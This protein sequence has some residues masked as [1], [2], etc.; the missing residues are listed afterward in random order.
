MSKERGFAKGLGIQ[1]LAH[2]DSVTQAWPLQG[3]G[4]YI[5]YQQTPQCFQ[6][7]Y[8]CITGVVSDFLKGLG[9]AA[10]HILR[11]VGLGE[12]VL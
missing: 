8:E 6:L 3:L 4:P 12:S 5:L 2:P 9:A 11:K 1:G 10:H 7:T